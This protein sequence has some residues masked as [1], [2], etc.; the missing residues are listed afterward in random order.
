MFPVRFA[1]LQRLVPNVPFITDDGNHQNTICLQAVV[2]GTAVYEHCTKDQF[3]K[4]Y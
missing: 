3:S 1:R 4:V 2:P